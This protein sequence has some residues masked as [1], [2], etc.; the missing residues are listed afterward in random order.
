[1][2]PSEEGVG[3]GFPGCAAQHAAADPG[4]TLV[5]GNRNR[6]KNNN[7]QT[8]YRELEDQACEDVGCWANG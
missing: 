6:R 3:L 2:P 1:M 8:C 7:M 5:Y 4:V